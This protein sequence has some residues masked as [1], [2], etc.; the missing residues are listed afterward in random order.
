MRRSIPPADRAQLRD[1][2]EIFVREERETLLS[3][4]GILRGEIP[5]EG[6]G[7]EQ[8]LDRVDYLWAHFPD[9]AGAGGRRPPGTDISFLKRVRVELDPC[10]ALYDRILIDSAAGI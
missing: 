7:L 4:R 8:L 5:P 10:I 9:C 1:A 3:L 2:L 6:D